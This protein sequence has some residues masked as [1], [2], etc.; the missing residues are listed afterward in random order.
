MVLEERVA[1]IILQDKHT[2]SQSCIKQKSQ[3]IQKKIP[4]YILINVIK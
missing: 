1:K 3:Y 2:K 4:E